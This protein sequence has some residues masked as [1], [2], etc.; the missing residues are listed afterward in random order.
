M[1]DFVVL[2]TALAHAINADPVLCLA[3][4]VSWLDP[5]H[6]DDD[7]LD[8]PGSEQDNVLIALH[9]LR[10]SMPD[11]YINALQAVRQ[12][13]TYPQLDQLICRAVQA[14]GI[15]LDHLE[16]MG[17]GIPLPAYGTTLDDEDFYVN[18]PDII[19][20]LDCFDVPIEVD[21]IPQMTYTV[22]DTIADDLLKQDN[23][24]WRQVGW[25]IKWLFGLSNNSCV[26]WDEVMMGVVQPLSWDADDIIF[27]RE[28]IEEADGIMQ[29][30]H[31]GLEWINQH[32]VTLE[33][34]SLN[35]RK[36]YQMKGAEHAQYKFEWP[37]ITGRDERRTELVA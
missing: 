20:L 14:E 37:C 1:N 26:D 15:P 6:D 8:M 24:S 22:A 5:L 19:P 17:W 33:I 12:G 21:A 4:A 7:D 28:I 9:I 10:K 27:A 25:L 18:H 11:I 29:D 34:L 3:H 30:A 16:W 23:E 36:T 2:Q 31:N 32:P 35:I 13:A